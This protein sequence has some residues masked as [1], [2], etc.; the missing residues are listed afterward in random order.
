VLKTI[1]AS[2]L[3]STLFLSGCAYH[4][5]VKD[6]RFPGG[7]EYVA[8]PVFKNTTQE[9]GSEVFFTN[10]LVTELERAKIVA[11]A[12]KAAAQVTLEGTIRSITYTPSSQTRAGDVTPQ[13]L[14]EGTVL[15]TEYYVNVDVNIVAKRNSDQKIIWS[16]DFKSRRSYTAPRIGIQGLNSANALYNHSARYQNIQAMANDMMAEAHDRLTENF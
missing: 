10:A 12:D 9:T 16:S 4:M 3:L 7:Y 13:Y 5:G 11:I 14:P 2:T 15:T 1:F 8:V 6:R